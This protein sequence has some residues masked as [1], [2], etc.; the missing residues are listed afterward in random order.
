MGE[1]RPPVVADEVEQTERRPPPK[2]AVHLQ[3]VDDLTPRTQMLSRCWR[4]VL[5]DRRKLNRWRR[6]GSKQCTICSPGGMSPASYD[7]LRGHS[8]RSGQ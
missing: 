6:N 5:R 1:Q 3:P 8:T 2:A 7:Q 4:K